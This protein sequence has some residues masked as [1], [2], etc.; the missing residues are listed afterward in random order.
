MRKFKEFIVEKLV[1]ICGVASIFFVILIFLFLLKEGLAV[2]KI[3]TPLDFLF[4]KSWYPISE[5][6]QLGILPLILG[7]LL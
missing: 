2:F 1:L 3:V 7:S 4:G 5:P 6:P